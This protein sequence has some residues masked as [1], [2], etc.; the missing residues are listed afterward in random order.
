MTKIQ[1]SEDAIDRFESAVESLATGPGDVRSR[2][3][4]AYLTIF[5]FNENELPEEVR[6]DFL[7]VAD[8]LTKKEPSHKRDDA[9]HAT[10]RHMNNS[11][12]SKIAQKIFDIY[13]FLLSKKMHEI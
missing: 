1:I 12:G 10:L 9:L 5:V 2:L 13:M 3:E 4:D 8:S 11:T 7:W 6:K